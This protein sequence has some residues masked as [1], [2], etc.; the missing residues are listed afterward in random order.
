MKQK[1]MHCHVP[2]VLH[3]DHSHE[4]GGA[5]LALVRL[6]REASG[7]CPSILLPNSVA[8]SIGVFE[9]LP[10]G[11]PCSSVGPAQSPGVSSQ[12]ALAR[13]MRFAVQV[14]AQAVAVR[15]SDEFKRAVVVHANTSR[16]GLYGALACMGTNKKL[17]LQ[18]RDQITRES[19]GFLGQQAFA[20]IALRRAN[21]I[22]SNSRSTL[23][24]AVALLGQRTVPTAVVHSPIG[25]IQSPKTPSSSSPDPLRIAMVARIDPWKGQSLLLESFASTF[26]EGKEE[27]FFA[28]G[29]LFGHEDYLLSLQREVASKGLQGRVHFLGHVEDISEVLSHVDVCVQASTR[30]EPLGQNVLQYLAAGKAVV[31]SN[32]GGPSEWISDGKNGLLFEPRDTESLSRALRRLSSDKNLLEKLQVAAPRTPGL[33]SDAEVAEAHGRIFSEV[34]K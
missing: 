6:I 1:Q 5:E 8:G 14:L 20:R 31:A 3:L 24:T 21:A 18:L 30:P 17:V 28:G 7:W 13:L 27:L 19:L 10:P 32:E 22:I 2:S 15:R 12:S 16:A 26:C 23:A 34:V 33:M 11:V 29:S 9:D 4:A 25:N